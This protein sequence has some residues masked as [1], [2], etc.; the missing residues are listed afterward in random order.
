MDLGTVLI[1]ILAV[2]FFGGIA[3]LSYTGRH[4]H[5]SKSDRSPSKEK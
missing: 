1:I 2:L 5:A 4:E 3:F